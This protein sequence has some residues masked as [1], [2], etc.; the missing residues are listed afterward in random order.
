MFE[1]LQEVDAQTAKSLLTQEYTI[2]FLWGRKSNERVEVPCNDS[3][4]FGVRSKWSRIVHNRD[5][6]IHNREAIEFH[7]K[8]AREDLISLGVSE[9][10]IRDMAKSGHV[11]VSI[12]FVQEAHGYAARTMPW[13]FVLGAATKKYRR[14]GD[15]LVTRHVASEYSPDRSGDFNDLLFVQSDPG[16]LKNIYSFETER[17]S[18]QS[19][20]NPAVGDQDVPETSDRET[21]FNLVKDPKLEE[22]KERLLSSSPS[23]L[24]ISGIDNNEARQL[25]EINA[26]RG[27]ID[28]GIIL[29]AADSTAE[30]VNYKDL[31]EM[32]HTLGENAPRL[33]V[34]NCYYSASRLA[35]MS[36]ACGVRYSIGFQD[37]VEDFIAEDFFTSFYFALNS[38]ECSDI[39]H[40]FFAALNH[41]KR[42]NDNLLG[43]G[44]VLVSSVSLIRLKSLKR[45]R[46]ERPEAL[47]DSK[48]RLDELPNF[49]L[50]N[51]LHLDIEVARE[52]NYSMLHNG[53]SIFE[54]F[55]FKTSRYGL[56]QNVDIRVV[57]QTGGTP[58]E[59][60]SSFDIDK[61]TEIHDFVR[62]PLTWDFAQ[63][64]RETVIATVLVEVT[65]NQTTFYKRT[66]QVRIHPLNEWKDNLR[67]GGWLPSF[68]LPRDPGVDDV[69]SLARRNL[70]VLTSNFDA[71]FDGYQSGDPKYVDL[72][73]EAIWSALSFQ[74]DIGYIEPPPSYA[75]LSQRLRTPSEILRTTQ[76]TCIDL[77]LL[78]AACI[79]YVG[80]Y[81]VLFLIE[82]HAFPGYWRDWQAHRDFTIGDSPK[83][84]TS[85]ATKASYKERVD[86]SGKTQAYSRASARKLYPFEYNE[87][88]FY[89]DILNAVRRGDLAPIETTRITDNASILDAEREGVANLRPRHA[90]DAM[91]D[92]HT[93]RRN[94]VTPLPI[95]TKPS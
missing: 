75:H 26:P 60:R 81:P 76:G 92:V 10:Q 2:R 23:I 25:A 48:P 19:I 3:R 62:I 12:D 78:Y 56:I 80:L 53:R 87:A 15:F 17:Q 74:L 73:A 83:E 40:A 30:P 84:Y 44:F 72:Q 46:A 59:Y 91:L 35:M 50:K 38:E 69:I 34:Y 61:P 16:E 20:F 5:R 52:I 24:H 28:D 66:H 22:L 33:V 31:A 77:G 55:K 45:L 29:S 95:R 27:P 63:E 39:L 54:K 11:E 4:F 89:T 7:R 51:D 13:E 18:I 93:A 86:A 71:S 14:S 70:V 68:V 1:P 6:W 90:F 21:R 64:L 94:S 8:T 36:A 41:L 57:L 47:F 9:A 88:L 49:N 79:E 32:F 43:I 82:G 58:F 65:H 37:T 85:E 42:H 67:D